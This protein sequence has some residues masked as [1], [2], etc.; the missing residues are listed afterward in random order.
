ML[1]DEI[2]IQEVAG[3]VTPGDDDGFESLNSQGS[4]EDVQALQPQE[5][6]EAVFRNNW[7]QQ[8][9]RRVSSKFY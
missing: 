5:R 7:L 3:G 4:S 2:R 1:F 9:A 6:P 8:S